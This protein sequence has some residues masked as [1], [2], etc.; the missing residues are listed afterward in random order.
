MVMFLNP[1]FYPR[2]IVGPD[3]FV[4]GNFETDYKFIHAVT[5]LDS[6]TTVVLANRR[7]AASDQHWLSLN[8]SLP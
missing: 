2:F 1:K 3:V 6:S 7:P 8:H 5:L 4:T